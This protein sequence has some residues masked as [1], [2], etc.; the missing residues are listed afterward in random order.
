MQDR[1]EWLT[2]TSFR[3]GGRL[4][5]A[6]QVG[7]INV[8]PERVR[9]VI[10]AHPD[11]REAAVRPMAAH[12]GQRLKAFIVPAPGAEL[13]ALRED[14]ARWLGS[15]LSAP[16]QPKA[17]NFGTSLPVNETGKACDWPISD[18]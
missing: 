13:S 3:I 16:E 5:T 15:R 18:A 2:A 7:G 17:F 11:V 6:V 12:E 4:D 8:F 9:Q 14:I 1:V 10:L